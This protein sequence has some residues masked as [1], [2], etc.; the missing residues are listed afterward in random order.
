MD[1]CRE[2]E[3]LTQ[4]LPRPVLNGEELPMGDLAGGVMGRAAEEERPAVCRR[5]RFAALGFVAPAFAVGKYKTLR[6]PPVEV[7][8]L[9]GQQAAAAEYAA[10]IPGLEPLVTDWFGPLRRELHIVELDKPEAEPYESGAVLFTPLGVAERKSLQMGLAHSLTHAAFDSPRLWIE[11]GAAHFAQALQV[12]QQ[13]G[14]AAAITYMGNQRPALVEAEASPAAPADPGATPE[15][16][17]ASQ[18]LINSADAVFYRT[19]AMYVFWM[20]RDLL[21]DAAL[22][23]ALKNY[24]A[25]DDKAPAYLQSLA[26]AQATARKSLEWFF[27]DWVYRDR[28]LPDFRIAAVYARPTLAG[29]FGVT[30]T[31]EN[32]GGAGAEVSVYARSEH[33]QVSERVL[34]PA[35]GKGVARLLI[36]EKP[37]EVSVN[38]GSVPETDRTNNSAPVPDKPE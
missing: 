13:A 3:G 18:S 31:V 27:D 29:A 23:R 2:L 10:A 34:V 19:K 8:Y 17:A 12:E 37:R 1:F 26:E 21:G 9:P 24:R 4:D 7:D 11:E 15:T 30:V 32:L 5:Y 25:A 20:L 14:R 16:L 35:R 28:G 38:D 33:G 36:P 22:Q 6:Q